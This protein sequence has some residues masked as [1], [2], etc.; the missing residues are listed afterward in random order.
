MSNHCLGDFAG[1]TEIEPMSKAERWMFFHCK[2]FVFRG[3]PLNHLC[4]RKKHTDEI[5]RTPYPS[6]VDSFLHFRHLIH[7][8][9]FL[10]TKSTFFSPVLQQR[11]KIFPHSSYNAISYLGESNICRLLPETLTADIETIFADQ[12]SLVCAD[13]AIIS[14]S[15]FSSHFTIPVLRAR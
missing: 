12:T 3:A 10:F 7:R 2:K 4:S 14:I 8:S 13:A 15:L 1:T 11:Q 6:Y 5:H 9:G